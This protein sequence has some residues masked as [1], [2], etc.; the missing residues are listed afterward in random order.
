MIR[1]VVWKCGLWMLLGCLA[2][3]GAAAKEKKAAQPAGKSVVPGIAGNTGQTGA[4]YIGETV[5]VGCHDKV[6]EQF[7]FNVHA[8][9]KDFETRGMPSRCEGCHGPGSKHAESADVQAI[10]R[11]RA[12]QR[13]DRRSR[14]KF[15]AGGQPVSSSRT[16]LGCHSDGHAEAWTGSTHAM[17]GLECADCH[18]I[19]Q[20]RRANTLMEKTLL[21]LKSRQAA[22]PPPAS[23]LA[24][25]EPELC[26]GCHR[27]KRAQMNYSSHHPVREGRMSCSSC[28]AVHGSSGDKLLRTGGERVN[29]LCYTCHGSK[30]GPFVFEHAAVEEG[31]QSCH[32]PHGTVAR[33]LLRQNEPFLCLQC[34]EAHFHIGRSG[35]TGTVTL[36]TGASANPNGEA[37]WRAAFATKCTQ[38]HTQIHG[39]DLPS[40]SISSR[41][42]ALTR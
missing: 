4:E 13:T 28:H 20:S 10:G 30:Q 12:S 18:T 2:A 17:A 25:P 35:V 16:C 29:E 39:S 31:C 33:R 22:A 1:G 9:L 32:E 38:C 7:Q 14:V 6:V 42:K 27:E 21:G 37:G 15:L 3:G 26:Y 40:Q 34:H 24:A 8:R 11:F 36:P 19:H 41:G 23:S 5:C